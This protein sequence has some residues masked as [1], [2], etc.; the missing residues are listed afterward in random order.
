M[1]HTSYINIFLRSPADSNIQQN[2]E[3]TELINMSLL[4]T[5]YVSGHKV[6]LSSKRSCDLVTEERVCRILKLDDCQ[7]SSSCYTGGHQSP[8]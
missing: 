1:P 5:Y 3:T 2:L 6:T 4:S 7:A 8:E